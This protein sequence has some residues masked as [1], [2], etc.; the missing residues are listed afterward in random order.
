MPQNTVESLDIFPVYPDRPTYQ[1]VLG[2]QAP[3][4]DPTIGAI[5]LWQDPAAATQPA[6]AVMT[7]TKFNGSNT[8]PVLVT[9]TIP[10]AQAARV[11]LPGKPTYAKYFI[12]PTDA[13]GSYVL[14][15]AS[16]T[17][18][19]QPDTLSLQP[20]ATALAA[21][22]GAA[23]S[24]RSAGN[25]FVKYNWPADEPR[26]EWILTYK[27]GLT[28]FAGDLINSMN[29][30]GIGAPGHWDTTGGH[31]AWV[32]DP[33]P[34]GTD[35]TY[36]VL[37]VPKRPLAANETL[38]LVQEGGLG[39]SQVVVQTPDAPGTGTNTSDSAVLAKMAAQVQFVYNEM[40]GN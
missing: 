13:S 23:V 8:N 40:G 15:G 28:A 11:N 30:A 21:L 37:D 38:V 6:N 39:F 7:Y 29:Q 33:I 14:A 31:L 25:T 12:T 27:D 10:A 34:D 16:F 26:R 18:A 5:K 36:P 4:F 3:I 24:D 19:V 17:V 20:Q 2:T 1:N 32:V 35:K 22:V 9:F